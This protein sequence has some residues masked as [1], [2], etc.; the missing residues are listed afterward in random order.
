VIIERYLVKELSVTVMAVA[1][2]LFLIFITSWSA[3]L[4]ARVESGAI[5][6]DSLFYVLV[7]RSIEALTMLLPLALFLAV[8]LALGRL[9]KDSE[10]TAMLACGVS[11][12]KILSLVFWFAFV[13]SLLVALVALYW[14]PWS[15]NERDRLAGELKAEAGLEAISAGQFRELGNGRLVFYAERMSDD[16]KSMENVFVQGARDGVMNVM[17]AARAHRVEDSAVGG[18]YLV[19]E[20]GHRYEGT[21]GETGFRIIDFNEHGLLIERHQAS[22]QTHRLSSRPSLDLLASNNLKEV[23]ELQWRLSM[24]ISTVLLAMLA[25]YLSKTNPRQG[26]YAKFFLGVLIYIVY[27]NLLGV[28]RTWMEK[29]LVPSDIGLWWVH[30]I[31][32][33]ILAFLILKQWREQQRAVALLKAA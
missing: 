23:G 10:M 25:V 12:L 28:A 4:L 15:V 17:V 8:L 29:G 16:G 2:V 33:A 22:F 1:S 7:L 11:P 13:F 9:Y 14:G 19:L 6:V 21:P 27:N 3:G 18:D 31:V 24:P 26:R 5:Q 20:N 30:G 32:F